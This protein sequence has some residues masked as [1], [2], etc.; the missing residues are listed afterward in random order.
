MLTRYKKSQEK[1]AM[2]LLSFMPSEKDLKKLQHSIKEYES[3]DDWQ[4][5]FWKE[6][7]IIGLL[8][9]E[10]INDQLVEL[11]HLSVNPSHR[12]QGIGKKMIDE[13]QGIIGP[14]VEIIGN[15]FTSSFFEKCQIEERNI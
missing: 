12:Y 9:I 11:K 4:L 7:D 14:D 3:N 2:G 1:I 10:W 5:F 15:E 6:E 8:G 13:L